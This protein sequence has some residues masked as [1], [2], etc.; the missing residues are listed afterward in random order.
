MNDKYLV[1]K[2]ITTY[3]HGINVLDQCAYYYYNHNTK[4]KIMQ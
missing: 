4:A 3:N 2:L 1:Q